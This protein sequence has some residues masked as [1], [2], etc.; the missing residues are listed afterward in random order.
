MR[1]EV[2]EDGTTLVD[3]KIGF[4]HPQQAGVSISRL[5]STIA[6]AFQKENPERSFDYCVNCVME[7]VKFGLDHY[8][9]D[10]FREQ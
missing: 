6:K 5:V 10:A 1:I 3:I 9:D 7:G 8:H 4:P 2:F